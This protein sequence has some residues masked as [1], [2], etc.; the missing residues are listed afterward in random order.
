MHAQITNI[1]KFLFK[2]KN[3]TRGDHAPYCV[4]RSETGFHE[5]QMAMMLP[6]YQVL[7]NNEKLDGKPK[8]LADDHELPIV[9]FEKE[10][11][12]T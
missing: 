2:I 12:P 5:E 1:E 7:R 11:K 6:E 4:L 9:M 10:A 3:K 8:A